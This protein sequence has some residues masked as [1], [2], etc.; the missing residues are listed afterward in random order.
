[1]KRKKRKYDPLRSPG[2]W[3]QNLGELEQIRLVE[4][5]HHRSRVRLPN[6]RVHAAAHV[7]VE[8]QILLGDETPVAATLKRLQDEGLDRH[9]AIHAIGG[10]LMGIAWEAS[11]DQLES[12]PNEAYYRRLEELTAAKWLAQAEDADYDS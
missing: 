5:Y 7:A 4:T 6:V 10:E 3:W 12:D 9:N 8:N 1:M 11:N 2:P